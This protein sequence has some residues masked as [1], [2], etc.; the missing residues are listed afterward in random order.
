LVT[1][2][3]AVSLTGAG[4]RRGRQRRSVDARGRGGEFGGTHHTVVPEVQVEP[5]RSGA[6]HLD[7]EGDLRTGRSPAVTRH[8]V[9]VGVQVGQV[10]GAQRYQVSVRPQVG[11]EVGDGPAAAA[12]PQGHPAGGAGD[13]IAGQLDGVPVDGAR[14]RHRWQRHRSIA[15]G[16]GYIGTQRERLGQVGGAEVGEHPVLPGRRHGQRDTPDAVAAQGRVHVLEAGQV[17][18]YDD[19]VK[20]LLVGRRVSG[21]RVAVRAEHPEVE[22][23][24]R[25]R[26]QRRR[27]R[28][29]PIPVLADLQAGRRL[30]HP[31]RLGVAAGGGRIGVSV[32]GGRV[33]GHRIRRRAGERTHHPARAQ[34]RPEHHHQA[35]GVR[36]ELQWRPHS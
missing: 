8:T 16:S 14:P 25:A 26:C 30:H 35:D 6:G 3:M 33:V 2:A 4:R 36:A 13:E 21:H 9:R 29:Q 17:P 1:E 23:R 10:P 5:V 12:D 11:L 20:I 19:Q 32:G 31:T 34:R 7:V 22:L 15:A 28:L 18:A 27:Q 24:G